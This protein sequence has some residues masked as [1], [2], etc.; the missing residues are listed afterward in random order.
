MTC[1]GRDLIAVWMGS[2]ESSNLSGFHSSNFELY[3]RTASKPFRSRSKSISDTMRLVSGSCPNKRCL[4]CLMTF[5]RF[6]SKICLQNGED[7]VDSPQAFSILDP[8]ESVQ[9]ESLNVYRICQ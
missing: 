1:S 4:P 2:S 6:F 3:L 7:F 5:I 8:C 9:P